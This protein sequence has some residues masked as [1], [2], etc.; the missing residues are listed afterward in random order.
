MNQVK[1]ASF[2]SFQVKDSPLRE[3]TMMNKKGNIKKYRREE[4]QS[5]LPPDISIDR[6]SIKVT[7]KNKDARTPRTISRIKSPT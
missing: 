1:G 2:N 6:L 4:L 3:N 7:A 5:Q